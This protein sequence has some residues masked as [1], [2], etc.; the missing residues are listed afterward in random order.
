M[1]IVSML[2][3]LLVHATFFSNPSPNRES[4]ITTPISS[5]IFSYVEAIALV[6][7]N[8]FILISG[9]FSIRPKLK[10]FCNLV[11]IIYFY[12]LIFFAIDCCTH[13]FSFLNLYFTLNPFSDWF[14]G[15]YLGLYLLSPVLN[16]FIDNSTEKTFRVFLIVYITLQF[17]I[18]WILPFRSFNTYFMSFEGGY[19]VFAFIGLYCIARYI[20]IYG[21]QMLKRLLSLRVAQFLIIYF[22]LAF[23]NTLLYILFQFCPA[24]FNDY[25]RQLFMR[26]TNPLTVGSSLAL[27][28]FFTKI[29]ISE[30]S[31]LAKPILVFGRSAFAIYLIHFNFFILFYYKIISHTIYSILPIWAAVPVVLIYT[32]VFYTCC[33]GLD[34]IRLRIWSPLS[35]SIFMKRL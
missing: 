34:Q 25:L 19:S 24:S 14:V 29:H 8:C 11:F 21:Q 15:A 32:L 5:F 28:L 23:I 6:C 18:E 26:Y 20:K 22:I 4:F 9:Y 30:S 7:V 13:G 31:K 3:V 33:V 1:R 10:S 17:T 12:K 2:L 35:K 27:M 16:A